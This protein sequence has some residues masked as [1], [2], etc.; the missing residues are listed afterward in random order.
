MNPP[1]HGNCGNRHAAKPNNKKLLSHL[2]IACHPG[3]LKAWREKAKK[4]GMTRSAWAR[5]RLNA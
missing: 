1:P 3:E 2:H 5:Q 4:A